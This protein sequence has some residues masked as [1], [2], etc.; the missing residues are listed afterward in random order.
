MKWRTSDWGKR[1]ER[2]LKNKIEIYRFPVYNNSEV[3]DILSYLIIKK[4]ADWLL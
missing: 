3:V 2:E 4:E 1:A